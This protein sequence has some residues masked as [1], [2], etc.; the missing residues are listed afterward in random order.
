MI[1]NHS[2]LFQNFLS[3]KSEIDYIN[4]IV[5]KRKLM[6]ERS[7]DAKK[8][9]REAYEAQLTQIS[10]DLEGVRNQFLINS[11]LLKERVKHLCLINN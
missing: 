11:Q 2:L 10:I 4:S 1:R 5:H 8:D 7:S 9:E 6:V 3:I